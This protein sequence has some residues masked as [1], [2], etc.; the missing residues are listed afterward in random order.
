M[1]Y[2]EQVGQL[3]VFP[4]AAIR[5]LELARQPS[6]SIDD[7][8]Q[9]VSSD[10]ALAARIL[11]VVNSPLF[12]LKVRVSHLRR[13]LTLIGFTGTRDIAVSLALSGMA[14]ERLPWG[15]RLWR[16]AEATAWTC[17][18]LSRQSRL[19]D[20]DA[21]F[22]AG[23][24]HDFGLQ[25]L[26]VTDKN[27]T[28]TLLEEFGLHSERLL[29]AERMARGFHHAELGAACLS[30]WNLPG[31]AADLIARHHDPIGH[32]DGSSSSPRAAAILA[33]S[34][35]VADA[36]LDGDDAEDVCGMILDHPL[37]PHTRISRGALIVSVET[38]MNSAEHLLSR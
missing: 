11:K 27:A 22:V 14:Q 18:V 28:V 21:M 15:E 37:A 19:M 23:L 7:L 10:G 24:L 38:L 32:A 20:P 5:V 35:A 16:H 17:R 9:A 6:A 8:E 1:E 26:L 2:V 3:G 33:L 12:G 31:E 30:R 25:L 13:A 4:A 36:I 29:T 34:D